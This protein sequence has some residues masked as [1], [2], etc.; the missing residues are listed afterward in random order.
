M[1]FRRFFSQ[2][3]EK[4]SQSQLKII[5]IVQFLVKY[6]FCCLKC[7]LAWYF[8]LLLNDSK[9]LSLINYVNLVVLSIL[10]ILKISQIQGYVANFP[11]W[12][13]PRAPSQNCQKNPCWAMWF[14]RRRFFY[15][16][17]HHAP[18]AGPVWTP[19]AQLAGFI[20]RTTIHCYTQNMKG[21]GLVV[22]E[23]KIFLCFSHCKSM[24]AIC[25]HGNQ[26]SNPTWPKT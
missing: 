8:M 2:F 20:K 11:N 5:S 17:P 7:Y 25:C 10:N 22:S 26:S 4:N 14:R 18:G 6:K 3:V 12:K 13:G 23:K 16:L 1:R 19:G 9:C 21:L 15:V 24:G